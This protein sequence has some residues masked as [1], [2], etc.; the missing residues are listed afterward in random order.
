MLLARLSAI[1]GHFTTAVF[2]TVGMGFFVFTLATLLSMPKQLLVVYL[3]VVIAQSGNG[4]EPTSSKIVK[5]AVLAVST[6]VTIFVAI[7][8]YGRMHKARPIVQGQLRDR[9]Y[10]MLT[11]AAG[12]EE[13]LRPT[14]ISDES[15]GDADDSSAKLY[16]Q[17]R[18]DLY[19]NEDLE[20][21]SAALTDEKKTSR[22]KKWGKK[23][24]LS[25]TPSTETLQ[26]TEQPTT[27]GQMSQQRFDAPHQDGFYHVQHTAPVMQQRGNHLQAPD[28]WQQQ[29]IYQQQQAQ[30]HH[31]L[32]YQQHVTNHDVDQ[33]R[34]SAT[35]DGRTGRELR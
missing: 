27:R 32:E 6:L 3:G 23:N 22:W 25:L 17:S 28:H 34:P 20:S 4:A 11:D 24:K 16:G 12:G 14:G 31:Q 30:S 7:Y 18:S 35:F 33:Y 29:Q 26:I 21:S 9:R 10:Q 13:V 19:S 8:L 1:P 5:Y 2:A 15:L